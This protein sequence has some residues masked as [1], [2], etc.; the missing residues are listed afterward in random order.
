MVQDKPLRELTDLAR[1]S[2]RFLNTCVEMKV[3][4]PSFL[5]TGSCT[6]FLANWR[7][8]KPS[9]RNKVLISATNFGVSKILMVFSLISSNH[10]GKI[11]I[12]SLSENR[13]T[14]LLVLYHSPWL[15]KK[16]TK[17]VACSARLNQTRCASISS[18]FV[19][20]VLSCPVI[21][22]SGSEALVRAVRSK[23]K[24]SC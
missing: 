5:E 24:L 7:V 3:T 23:R 17:G 1:D 6:A 21:G 11:E 19:E 4:S 14:Q 2:Q 12:V 9:S 22:V 20:P 18:A 16:D 8:E 10:Y 13:K 15:S